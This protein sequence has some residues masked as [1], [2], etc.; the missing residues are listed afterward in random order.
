MEEACVLPLVLGPGAV[1]DAVADH[2]GLDAP[3]A[4][5]RGAAG[6]EVATLAGAGRGAFWKKEF[7][8]L[9][10]TT[11]KEKGSSK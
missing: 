7:V 5:G 1:G 3:V 4:P 6:A 9:R 2:V 8:T 11:N 10:H